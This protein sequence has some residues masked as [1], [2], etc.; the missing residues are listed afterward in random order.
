LNVHVVPKATSILSSNILAVCFHL[1]GGGFT[2]SGK[3]HDKDVVFKTATSPNAS[4]SIVVPPYIIIVSLYTIIIMTR[5][6][7]YQHMETFGN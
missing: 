6:S 5:I 2:V 3:V 1:G 4:S 7:L